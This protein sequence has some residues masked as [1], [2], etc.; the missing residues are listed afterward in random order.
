[1]FQLH[2]NILFLFFLLEAIDPYSPS[3]YFIHIYDILPQSCLARLTS[4]ILIHCTLH[5]WMPFQIPEHPS[6]NIYLLLHYPPWHGGGENR[7]AHKCSEWVPNRDLWRGIKKLSVSCLFLVKRRSQGR[8]A[9]LKP[10]GSADCVEL[11]GVWGCYYK[12]DF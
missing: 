9:W 12:P 5:G 10:L 6:P 1:M 2:L 4:P 8:T 11:A 3:L 7:M